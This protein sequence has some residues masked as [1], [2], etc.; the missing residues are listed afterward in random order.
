MAVF[1][2]EQ[3]ARNVRPVV[4]FGVGIVADDVLAFEH[5]AEREPH[6]AAFAAFAVES[7]I[8]QQISETGAAAPHY[9]D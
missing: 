6:I 2:R 7:M 4:G 8:G 1:E 3:Q 9:V 5:L